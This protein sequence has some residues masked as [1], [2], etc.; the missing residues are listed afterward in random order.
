MAINAGNRPKGRSI[1]NLRMVWEFA[2]RYRGRIACAAV[3]LLIAAASAASIPYGL[4]LV[5]DKGFA[6]GAG[7][8]HHI[9]KWF[10]ALLGVFVVMAVATAFRY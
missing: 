4:K 10:E 5:I 8:P 6:S 3:A 9:A 1:K 7:N 2:S